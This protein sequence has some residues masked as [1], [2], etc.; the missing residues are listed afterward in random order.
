M[1][2]PVVG[3]VRFP[4]SNCEDESVRALERAGVAAH[5]VRWNEP[6]QRIREHAA[7][8]LPGGFS[9]QDRVRAGAVAARLP[10]L[11]VLAERAAEGAPILGLCNGAQI[12]AEA[13]LVPG[14]GTIVGAAL[15]PNRGDRHR[16]YYTRWIH[17]APG[18][19]A[20]R[21][22]FTRG[23]TEAAP[24]PMAHAEGRFVAFGSEPAAALE[25]AGALR[26]VG[27]QGEDPAP[28]PWNPNGSQAGIA[29]LTNAAGNVLALMP[30]PERAQI[31]A[32]VPE[33]I[34]GAWG[35][36][37][38]RARGAAELE[39]DGPGAIVFQALARFLRKGGA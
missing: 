16:G 29:G 27:P 12:L 23:M 32:Q 21:C 35:E 9:Y 5:I 24:I 6:P 13:G 38:R 22:L 15:A 30:H 37:R 19:A 28:F 17:L 33:H 10:V 31:L 14:D 20:E 11:D 34:E 1:N 25:S 3:V 26:Y 4:G 39:A 36:R 18:P 8:L 7:Y 2:R